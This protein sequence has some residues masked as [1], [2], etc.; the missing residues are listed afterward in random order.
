MNTQDPPSGLARSMSVIA[1][2]QQLSFPASE[3]S[4]S[5]TMARRIWSQSVFRTLLGL[6]ILTG[7]LHGQSETRSLCVAPNSA[8]TPQR[9]GGAPGL[10]ASDKLS[11]RID[12]FSVQPWPKSESMKIDGLSVAA[13]HRVVIYRAGKAQQSFTFRFSEFKSPSPCL[14]LN[15]LYWTAQLWEPKDAPWCKCR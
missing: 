3:Q 8:E 5:S 10:C 2:L 4:I 9:C 13:R 14:F 1:W 6:T 7:S 12:H 15:D 11:L